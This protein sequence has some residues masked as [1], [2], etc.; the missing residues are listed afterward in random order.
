MFKKYTFMFKCIFLGG[1]HI[2]AVVCNVFMFPI[3]VEAGETVLLDGPGCG[4]G[5]VP[6]GQAEPA[7]SPLILQLQQNNFTG[8]PP[9]RRPNHERA[10]FA[11]NNVDRS[12]KTSSILAP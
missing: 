11:F 6:V 4:W 1:S 12:L 3:T 5:G 9:P 10:S 7:D 8:P 2:D